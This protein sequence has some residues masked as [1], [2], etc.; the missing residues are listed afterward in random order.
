MMSEGSVE[1]T[2]DLTNRNR[3]WGIFWS[4]ERATGREVQIHQ[5]PGL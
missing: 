5:R 1:Q 3:I 4:D 2:R